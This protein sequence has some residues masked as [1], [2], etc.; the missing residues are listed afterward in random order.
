MA[1]VI[2]QSV[3]LV[4][5]SQMLRSSSPCS[6]RYWIGITPGAQFWFFS[7]LPRLLCRLEVPLS[8]CISIVGHKR[9]ESTISIPKHAS[10]RSKAPSLLTAHN[11]CHDQAAAPRHPMP[12]SALE[13]LRSRV[14]FVYF[15]AS[16]LSK[17]PLSSRSK[18]PAYLAPYSLWTS[19]GLHVAQHVC[20]C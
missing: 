17:S 6:H 7:F 3:T 20:L 4:L 2:Q 9:F 16:S 14:S 19:V 5:H 13:S 11:L 8:V 1:R 18:R 12:T 10:S 15:E